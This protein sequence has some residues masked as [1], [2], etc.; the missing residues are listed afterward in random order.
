MFRQA[1]VALGAIC[2]FG[3]PSAATAAVGPVVVTWNIDSVGPGNDTSAHARAAMTY[4]AALTPLPQIVVVQEALQSQFDTY[5]NELHNRTGLAWRGVFATHC[6]PGGW[7][8]GGCSAAQD[9]GV[10]ILS[11]LPIVDATSTYLAFPDDWHSA[12]AAVRAAVN[13]SGRVV[14]V[15][16]AH[17]SNTTTAR[18]S[19]MSALIA[20]AHQFASPQLVAGDFNADPDQI[21]AS[22]AMGAS[23]RDA[24]SAVGSGPGYT[25]NAPNPTMHLDYWFSDISNQIRPSWATVVTAPGALSDHFPV[26]AAFLLGAPP[27]SPPSGPTG[28]RIAGRL[29]SRRAGGGNVG[30]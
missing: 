14:Q 17:M 7:T 26:H 25:A 12:R 10:G 19:M 9:E 15:F 30:R 1:L 21:D 27:P 22:G 5:I 20:Y 23:F 6:A 11:S 24:W 16:G 8:N 4:I 13:I 28:L 2:V 18:Y 3:L 29:S